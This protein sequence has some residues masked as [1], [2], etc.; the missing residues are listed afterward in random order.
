VKKNTQKQKDKR[1]HSRFV[2]SGNAYVAFKEGLTKIGKIKDI[3]LGGLSFEYIDEGYV[4]HQPGRMDIFTSGNAFYLPRIP[5]EIVYDISTL[6]DGDPQPY[7]S[8]IQM[9]RCGIQFG[10]LNDDQTADLKRFIKV[11]AKS[12]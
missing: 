5:G 1:K 12:L 6:K 8:T 9:N 2:I 3:S 7:F 10:N 11:F 4:S